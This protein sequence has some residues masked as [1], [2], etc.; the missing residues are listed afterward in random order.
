MKNE[1]HKITTLLILTLGVV[2]AVSLIVGC[3]KSADLIKQAKFVA[4]SDDGEIAYSEDGIN[5]GKT[6]L[7][8]NASWGSVCYGNGKFVVVGRSCNAT[9]GDWDTW[10]GCNIAAYSNDGIK[11]ELS[12]LPKMAWYGVCYGNGKFAAVAY[13]SDTAVY[14]TNGI[15]WAETTIP[16]SMTKICY[17][18]GKFVALHGGYESSGSDGAAYSNDGIRWF[19]AAMPDNSAWTS[20][21]YGNGKF[22][23]IASDNNKAAYS[24]D[25]IKWETTALPDNTWGRSVCYGDGKFVAITN[26][27]GVPGRN[28]A[29]SKDGIKWIKTTMPDNSFWTSVCYGNGKFVAIAKES[30]KAAYSNDGISWKKIT[31]PGK[32][33]WRSV[34]YAGE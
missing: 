19:E 22:V 28:G 3:G 23:A 18:D 8:G 20:I 17:G 15:N 27:D 14:S 13:M 4:I 9:V 16:Y 21:C 31:M 26:G 29:Y 30:N 10:D 34:C 2:L 7:S 11:W 25:G 33:D 5:W 24:K 32:E 1:N 12:E 6:K